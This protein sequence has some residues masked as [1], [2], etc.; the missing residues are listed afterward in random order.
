[1]P[2]VKADAYGHG[3]VL[4]ARELS[5]YGVKA[6]C[7]A[8]VSEGV[9]LRRNGIRGLIL[10]LGYTHPEQFSLL[11]RYRLTQTVLDSAYA[12]ELQVFGKKIAV[13]V[14]IDSGMHRLGERSDHFEDI[15]AIFRCPNLVIQGAFTHFG[16]DDTDSPS[17]KAFTLAQAQAFQAVLAQ[18][19]ERG[20]HCPKRHLLASYGLWN[21]PEFAADYVRVGI[22]LY[23]MLSTGADTDR[24]PIP[25][26]PVLSLKTRVA[27]VKELRAGES[28]GYG[29]DFVADT[30]R[31]IAV[32]TIGYADGLPRALSNGV[33]RVLIRGCEARIVG[34]VCM[35]QTL[36][37]VT[38]IPG[39]LS[40]DTA[41]LIGSSGG[42]ELTACSMA[43]QINTI[44]NEILS[45]LG[46][47]LERILIS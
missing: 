42:R 24:C 13:H 30:E 1:M 19:E 8:S 20:Y 22:A 46:K 32:L 26:R 47:R 25:L 9:E 11:R 28:A 31:R 36:V 7:V 5:R 44:S 41:V 45:R 12:K 15:Y 40:G 14:A 6:F 17:D 39:V 10:I 34:R 33:G 29:L 3:A 16:N 43:D 18:L 2:V 23:G 35:D 27:M 21:Y 4:I 37:D 38:E